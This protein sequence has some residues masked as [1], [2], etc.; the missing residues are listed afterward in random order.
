MAKNFVQN[1]DIVDIVAPAGGTTSGVGVL[2]GQL[3][4]VALSTVAAGSTVAVG[5]SG[6]WEVAKT[7][8]LAI[9]VGDPLYWDDTN[10][11]V[12]KTA[13]AQQK[14]GI[15]VSAAANPSATVRMLI[16]RPPAAASA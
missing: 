7:S 4:G 14:V 12:N 15:A 16:Q 9:S 3:F 10:K 6:V 8:A 1:G 11:V 5:V 13:T 2:V